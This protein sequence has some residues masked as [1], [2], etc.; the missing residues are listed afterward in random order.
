[1][2]F[3]VD[4]FREQISFFYDMYEIPYWHMLGRLK[5]VMSYTSYFQNSNFPFIPASR[6]CPFCDT[7]HMFHTLLNTN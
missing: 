1:M 6:T 2:I 4:P 3:A 7:F 5:L